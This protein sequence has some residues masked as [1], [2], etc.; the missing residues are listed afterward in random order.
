M[1][2]TVPNPAQNLNLLAAY[3][4]PLVA[5]FVVVAAMLL[6]M[7]LTTAGTATGVGSQFGTWAT[8]LE[9]WIKGP[10]GK[11]TML[12]ALL[13]AI[14]AFAWTRDLKVIVIPV[15]GAIAIGLVVSL[16][17]GSFTALI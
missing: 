9:G 4:R 8:T 11:M 3:K 16:I 10:Y 17:T 13:I 15:V 14:G 2:L 1:E 7:G 12:F 5:A 6:W